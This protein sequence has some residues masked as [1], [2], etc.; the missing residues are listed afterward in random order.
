MTYS[1][2]D[3]DTGT[4]TYTR[5]DYLDEKCT[6]SEYYSQFVSTWCKQYV[7]EQIGKDK[8]VSNIDPH[9]NDIP[10][11]KW[12]ALHWEIAL[13]PHVSETLRRVQDTDGLTMS[14]TVCIAKEAARHW[15]YERQLCEND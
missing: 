1:R 6:H 5:Q 14:N 11:C 3:T 4:H 8:L 7:A 15:L 9:M 2:T 12:D 13:D 10:A